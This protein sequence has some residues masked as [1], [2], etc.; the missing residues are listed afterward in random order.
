MNNVNLTAPR[1]KNGAVQ[2][3]I[4]VNCWFIIVI[5]ACRIMTLMHQYD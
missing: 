3:A 2:Q 1:I 5:G 4:A